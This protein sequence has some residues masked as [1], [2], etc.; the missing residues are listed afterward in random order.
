VSGQAQHLTLTPMEAAWIVEWSGFADK[1]FSLDDGERALLA[2][3]QLVADTPLVDRP[4]CGLP[5]PTNRGSCRM[6]PNHG[7]MHVGPVDGIH[8]SWHDEAARKD[9]T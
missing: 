2:R 1:V 7:G 4:A 6:L 5:D 8:Q 3:V 9:N